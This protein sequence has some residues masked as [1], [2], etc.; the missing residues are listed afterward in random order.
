MLSYLYGILRI[1][2]TSLVI[3]SALRSP[4]RETH[5]QVSTISSA[6]EH[7]QPYS[8]WNSSKTYLQFVWKNA[9][10]KVILELK[11]CTSTSEISL[12]I[13]RAVP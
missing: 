3:V 5:R 4:K 9:Q 12:L 10:K 6:I 13:T 11:L 2:R 1:A 7:Y 8:L